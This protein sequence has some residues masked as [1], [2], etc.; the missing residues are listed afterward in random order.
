M[1]NFV[2][3]HFKDSSLK[4]C[5]YKNG[6]TCPT[7]LSGRKNYCIKAFFASREDAAIWCKAQGYSFNDHSAWDR[8]K[9]NYYYPVENQ[10]T[11]Q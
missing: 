8:P 10:I 4:Y 6:Y 11:M 2:Q 5:V 7:L 1:E 9:G 3:I